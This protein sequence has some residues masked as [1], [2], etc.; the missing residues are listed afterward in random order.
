[1][2]ALTAPHCE[3][4]DE[5]DSFKKSISSEDTIKDQFDESDTSMNENA[6][7]LKEIMP[8]RNTKYG[9]QQCEMFFF[10]VSFFFKSKLM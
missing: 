8:R 6:T 1:M 3:E 7:F 5:N 2:I 9:K 4:L 10:I